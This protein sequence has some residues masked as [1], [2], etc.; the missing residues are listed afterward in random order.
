VEV[1]SFLLQPEVIHCG[2]ASF[3]LAYVLEKAGKPAVDFPIFVDVLSRF[4]AKASRRE[5]VSRGE[6]LGVVLRLSICLS[7]CLSVCLSVCVYLA[8]NQEP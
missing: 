8:K 1:R 4:S 2:L 3:A 5:K 6:C 7:I